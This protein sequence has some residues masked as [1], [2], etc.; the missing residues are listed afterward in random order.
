MGIL[1]VTQVTM[2][3]LPLEAKFPAFCYHCG[4]P[5]NN[6]VKDNYPVYHKMPL[7][8]KSETF[9]P[10]LFFWGAFTF[11]FT[12]E[13]VRRGADFFTVILVDFVTLCVFMAIAAIVSSYN[14]NSEKHLQ[15]QEYVMLSMPVCLSCADSTISRQKLLRMAFGGFA[16]IMTPFIILLIAGIN[17]IAISVTLLSFISGIILFIYAFIYSKRLK[18]LTIWK[19]NDRYLWLIRNEKFAEEFVTL[20]KIDNEKK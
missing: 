9:L 20:N 15:P 7:K 2:A 4:Q 13:L 11:L 6:I 10:V 14:R 5:T 16:L 12:I 1:K 19:Y 3:C 18:S 17:F 8:K